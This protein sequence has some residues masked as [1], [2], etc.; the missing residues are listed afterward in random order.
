MC[1]R[2]VVGRIRVNQ[3]QIGSLERQL[4]IGHHYVQKI[5][6]GKY[7]LMNIETTSSQS[8]VKHFSI[9]GHHCVFFYW[10]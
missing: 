3:L 9:Y 10:V 2:V 8:Q 6:M 5:L 1:I 7:G 4:I